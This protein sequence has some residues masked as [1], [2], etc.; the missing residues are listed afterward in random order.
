MLDKNSEEGLRENEKIEP[1]MNQKNKKIKTNKT[2][3]KLFKIS[4][5]LPIN[6]DRDR[7]IEIPVGLYKYIVVSEPYKQII[8]KISE[9]HISND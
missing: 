5:K 6:N 4:E 3:A 8:Q 9:I 1:T 2:T 7:K